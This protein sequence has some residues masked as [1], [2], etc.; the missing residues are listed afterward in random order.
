M[1]GE[2]GVDNKYKL[3][4]LKSKILADNNEDKNNSKTMK[5]MKI[6]RDLTTN[7]TASTWATTSFWLIK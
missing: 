4:I 7:S 2:L 5:T 1:K 3:E 6:S